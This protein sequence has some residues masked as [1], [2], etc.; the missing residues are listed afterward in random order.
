MKTFE[1][2]AEMANGREARGII[3]ATDE[4][5]A[6]LKIRNDY[7]VVTHISE[8]QQKGS[9]GLNMEI[10][11]PRKI[12]QKNLSI[13]CKQ[14][15]ITLKAGVPI[16]RC[17]E[18]IG[19]QTEDKMLKRIITQ[20]AEDVAEGNGLAS[21][22]NRNGPELPPTFIET[23]RAGEESGNLEHSFD[24]MADYYEKAYK[25]AGKIKSALGY[26]MFVLVVA[27]V[28][29]FIVMLFV[30]P[31]MGKTFKDLGGELPIMTKALISFSDF[32]SANWMMIVAVMASV[33]VARSVFLLTEKGKEMN[34]LFQLRNT[35]FGKIHQLAG[36]AQFANTMA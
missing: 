24:E 28:V 26:P 9:T 18:L 20:T 30:M 36:A 13:A 29:L 2:R 21:S 35:G 1:Y 27:I 32:F 22:L 8:V 7:P 25:N 3:Q 16:A 5:S 34:G 15:A 33:L 17:L 14:I 10:G 6:I 23:M 4:Y 11:G 12:N 19:R 31:T